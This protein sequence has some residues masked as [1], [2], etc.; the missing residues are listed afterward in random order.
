MQDA[1]E[2]RVYSA[3]LLKQFDNFYS[4]ADLPQLVVQ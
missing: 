1:L 4:L 3:K 2:M